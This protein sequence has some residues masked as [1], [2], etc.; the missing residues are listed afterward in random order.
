MSTF[1]RNR[2]VQIR[3]SI[4]LKNLFHVKTKY[5]PCDIGTRPD[6]VSADDVGP[7]S[8]WFNGLYWMKMDIS[9]AVEQEIL[10]PVDKL[11]L[12]DDEKKDFKQ[13]L[14]IDTEP[15][16]LTYGHVATERRIQAILDRGKFSKDLYLVN[17]GKQSFRKTS[18]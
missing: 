14:V 2:V 3:R 18:L 13:G 4:N 7:D 1:H 16:V 17:P 8:Q 15:E 10:V 12:S 11:R 9:E 6:K 5:Q